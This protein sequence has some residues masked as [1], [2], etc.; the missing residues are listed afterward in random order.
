M[1]LFNKLVRADLALLSGVIMLFI[2]PSGVWWD[3]VLG[4]T[5]A[6]LIISL[7]NHAAH[8]KQTKKLY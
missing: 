5:A 2:V 6:G 4:F 7:F 3:V 1:I 8:Y